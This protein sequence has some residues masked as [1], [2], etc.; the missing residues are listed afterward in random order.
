MRDAKLR[1]YLGVEE[2]GRLLRNNNYGALERMARELFRLNESL[3]AFKNRINLLSN[4]IILLEDKLNLT[5][6]DTPTEKLPRYEKKEIR[7]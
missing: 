4:K 3:S 2:D 7:K 5:Y 6:I 1:D